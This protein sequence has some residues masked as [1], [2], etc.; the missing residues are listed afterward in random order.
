MTENHAVTSP[1]TTPNPIAHVSDT[2]RWVAMYRAMETEREEALR[3]NRTMRFAR[4]WS[5]LSRWYPRRTREEMKRMSGV[6][7]LQRGG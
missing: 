3:L 4:F 7:L 6:V 1:V 2:A 5:W